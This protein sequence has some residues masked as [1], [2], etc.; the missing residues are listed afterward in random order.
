MVIK[1]IVFWVGFVAVVGMVGFFLLG[2]EKGVELLVKG[3]GLDI[4]V[5]KQYLVLIAINDYDNWLDLMGPVKDALGI[6]TVV[7]KN[8]YLDETVRLFDRQATKE[9]IVRLFKDLQHRLE[10]RDSVLIFYAGHGHWD[11][12]SNTGY[13]IPADAGVDENRMENWI[14]NQLI[15]GLVGNFKARHVLL[16]SDSC[17]SGDLV[18]RYRSGTVVIDNAYFQKAYSLKSR[19]VMTSGSMERVPDS[20]EFARQ[21]KVALEQNADLLLD[22]VSLFVR[23]RSG[24]KGSQPLFG[25]MPAMG[26]EP[27]ATFLLFRKPGKKSSPSSTAKKASPRRQWG[28]WMQTIQSEFQ[29]VNKLDIDSAVTLLRKKRSWEAFLKKLQEDNPHSGVDN[30]LKAYAEERLR[31]WNKFKTPEFLSFEGNRSLQLRNNCSPVDLRDIQTFLRA[32]EFFCA[33]QGINGDYSNPQGGY[34]GRLTVGDKVAVDTKTGLMWDR[35]GSPQGMGFADVGGWIAMMNKYK[36]GGYGDW[37]LPTAEEAA[38]LLRR[39]KN[40]HGLHIDSSFSS[41]Q[42]KIWTCDTMSSGGQPAIWIINFSMGYLAFEYEV[43]PF[44]R[45]VRSIT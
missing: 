19:Q 22:P 16:V 12:A 31:Y 45:A 7:L 11:Q 6:Q 24:V 40:P 8:Y 30:H 25:D 38:S 14:P 35:T 36:Y 10:A 44:V 34:S 33:N 32:N 15:T 41:I 1:R 9:A 21:L 5:G 37:R 20:S 43:G 4:E 18:T 13:W 17:Y 26:H 27:G 28:D 29:K 39:E 3:E 23:V 42:F 2:Q